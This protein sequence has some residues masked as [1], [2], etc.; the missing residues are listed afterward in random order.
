MR[1]PFGQRI[2]PGNN[3]MQRREFIKC[4][5]GAANGGLIATL[6]LDVPPMLRAIVTEVI[7]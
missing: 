5:G 1:D 6:G 7:E 4:L 2:G 3:R